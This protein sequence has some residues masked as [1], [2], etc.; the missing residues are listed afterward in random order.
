MQTLSVKI[1]LFS[2]ILPLICNADILE[3]KVFSSSIK[4]V[5]LY[6]TGYD[7]AMPI[8]NLKSTE[9]LELHFDDLSGQIKNYYYTV[10]QCQSNWTPTIMNSMEYIEGFTEANINDYD[11]SEGTKVSYVH[12]KLQFP[13]IDMSVNRSGNYILMVY[14]YDKEHPILTRRFMVTESKVFIDAGVAYT[15]SFYSRDKFQEVVFK[16]NYKGFTIDNPQMEIKASIL[17]N[18]RWDNAKIDVR[19]QFI[20]INEL[21]FDLNGQLLFPTSG[22]EFRFFDMRSLRF[23]GQNIRAFDIRENYNDVYLLYDKPQAQ[24]NYQ[25]IKDLNGLFYIDNLDNPNYN[26]GSDYAN[27][28]FSFDFGGTVNDGDFYVVGA[29]NNWTYDENSKMHYDVLDKSYSATILLKQ[30]TY[31]YSYVFIHDKDKTKDA[32]IT[33]GQYKDTENDYTIL[34]YYTP[35][36]ERYDRLISVKHINS[37]LNR[38]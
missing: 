11:Y 25:I 18:Y 34:L 4:T 26:S 14:D 38:F 10:I 24:N 35:F 2:F 27:V 37:I 16:V 32:F 7:L 28:H 17:Q 8:I 19:P 31:N 5:Q 30:G 20:G 22:R 36:G 29:F 33:E 12:Y 3:N 1:L 6:P 15:R 23:R 13:N 9:T 21:N